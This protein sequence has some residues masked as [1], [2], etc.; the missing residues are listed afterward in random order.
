MSMSV[1][2]RGR[3]LG[4]G[5]SRQREGRVC[6]CRR[7]QRLVLKEAERVAGGVRGGRPECT[8]DG[9]RGRVSL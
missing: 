5:Q 9:S 2:Q 6:K 3:A 7:G 8:E 4:A 1:S